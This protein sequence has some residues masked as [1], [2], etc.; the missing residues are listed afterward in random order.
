[1]VTGLAH[2]MYPL[3]YIYGQKKTTVITRDHRAGWSPVI[4]VV[5]CKKHITKG[6][7]KHKFFCLCT[8]HS[9]N[10]HIERVCMCV[11]MC[12]LIL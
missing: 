12:V 10:L 7:K 1:V 8:N 11:C 9:F 2:C 5:F 6:G 4:T 3:C